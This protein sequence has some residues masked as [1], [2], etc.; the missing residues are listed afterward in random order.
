MADQ[1][2]DWLM[3]EK[4]VEWLQD[5]ALRRITKISKCKGLK[6]VKIG[7]TKPRGT[8]PNWELLAFKPAFL[9][10]APLAD[11]DAMMVIHDMQQQYALKRMR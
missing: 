2:N 9:P 7:P 11:H 5:E 10:N 6:A 4:T 3:P 8:G 1:Q